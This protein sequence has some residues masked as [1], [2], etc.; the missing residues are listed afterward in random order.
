MDNTS[1]AARSVLPDYV[2]APEGFQM[3]DPG[4]P[5]HRA[6]PIVHANQEFAA[7]SQGFWVPNLSVPVNYVAPTVHDSQEFASMP[8]AF[9]QQPPING[10][11]FPA[12]GMQSNCAMANSEAH[13]PYHDVIPNFGSQE[14]NVEG[15]VHRGN[16]APH[17]FLQQSA[18]INVQNYYHPRAGMIPNINPHPYPIIDAPH[19]NSIVRHP[20]AHGDQASTVLQNAEAK[21]AEALQFAEHASRI[22][23]T[24]NSLGDCTPPRAAH[25][26]KR[27]L[28]EQGMG[29]GMHASNFKNEDMLGDATQR[30]MGEIPVAQ[31]V[32]SLRMP[33]ESYDRRMTPDQRRN[34]KLSS[35]MSRNLSTPVEHTFE[36]PSTPENFKHP[37][38]KKKP[39]EKD[40]PSKKKKISGVRRASAWPQG[41]AISSSIPFVGPATYL[42]PA[43]AA[44]S[45]GLAAVPEV[46]LEMPATDEFMVPFKP[47][48]GPSASYSMHSNSPLAGFVG[49]EAEANPPAMPCGNLAGSIGQVNDSMSEDELLF[50]GLNAPFLREPDV[51]SSP[52]QEQSFLR[53]LQATVAEASAQE[54]FLPDGNYDVGPH[55]FA[56]ADFSTQRPVLS[57]G[58]NDDPS[59]PDP[60]EDASFSNACDGDED[61]WDLNVSYSFLLIILKMFK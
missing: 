58:R 14:P 60:A 54:S 17:N 45:L 29:A 50:P 22:R 44:P 21:H 9:L 34:S 38:R 35:M 16:Q 6:A 25:A 5:G 61:D 37:A 11:H 36:A 41:I 19:Q 52:A 7:M 1:H 59:R 49:L 31:G 26:Y 53:A 12:F 47:F 40:S 8:K 55:V 46:L 20:N 33:W 43:F 32:D 2:P 28:R 24:I 18:V 42:A 15:F 3:P 56:G 27:R 10:D 39:P 13:L 30:I 23:A 57:E 4:F 51:A 48:S